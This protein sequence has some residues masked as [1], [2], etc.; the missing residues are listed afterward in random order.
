MLLPS[1]SNKGSTSSSSRF[2]SSSHCQPTSIKKT[3]ETFVPSEQE[4]NN[5]KVITKD[6]NKVDIDLLSKEDLK[7]NIDTLNSNVNACKTISGHTYASNK[8]ISTAFPSYEDQV[9]ILKPNVVKY[10]EDM[11]KQAEAIEND[12]KLH[13]FYVY[14]NEIKTYTSE[15]DKVDIANYFDQGRNDGVSKK[16]MVVFDPKGFEEETKYTV[17]LATDT[18]FKNYVAASTFSNY[19][20]FKNLLADKDYYYCVKTDDYT[21]Q[22]VH[23]RTEAYGRMID[24]RAVINVRDMGG[25]RVE[26]NKRIK[27]G[28]VF[29]GAQMVKE[30]YYT[31]SGSYKAANMD[32]ET[33]RL[34]QKDLR[35]KYE[36]DLR[37]DAELKEH[38]AQINDEN[39]KCTYH[40]TVLYSYGDLFKMGIEQKRCVASFFHSVC[41]A[42][43]EHMYFHCVAGADRTGMYGFLLGGLLGMS[44]TDLIIDYE[45]TSFSKQP[46]YH[47]KNVENSTQFPMFIYTIKNL[48]YFNK[49]ASLSTNI[50]N[51]L[52]NEFGVSKNDISTI[53]NVM[54]EEIK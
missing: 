17:I 39:Y 41:N 40:Q 27:Q 52:V 14:G 3:P 51:I 19:V 9:S 24:S 26:G 6:F 36:E 32:T 13:D 31:T 45:L 4:I 12:Y 50:E 42:E 33:F 7:T 44:Y 29:R 8:Y 53:K 11:H 1:C 21:S 16:L 22:T 46:R 30:G 48:S 15:T 10:I 18:E 49:E 2:S 20:T 35:I 28:L 37:N 5:L 25:R 34:F 38:V 23:F 47:Y 54:L 43:A